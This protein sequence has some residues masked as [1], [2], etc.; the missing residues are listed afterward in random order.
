MD[1]YSPTGPNSQPEINFICQTVLRVELE[2]HSKNG[3]SSN[4]EPEAHDKYRKKSSYGRTIDGTVFKIPE[5]HNM[6]SSLF[7]P[8]LP[9][10]SSDLINL[11]TLTVQMIPLILFPRKKLSKIYLIWFL[12][13]RLLYNVGL[14]WI[15]KNQS[16]NKLLIK[17]VKNLNLLDYKF[18]PRLSCW[19][20]QQL[21]SKML[22]PDLNYD[23]KQFPIEFNV[24]LLF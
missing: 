13:W 22:T 5:T 12:V 16:E 18:N 15:L 8:R 6:I 1:N 17:I 21:K 11:L 24:W 4:T 20:E 7:D 23:L 10:S 3:V 9:K 2:N 19:I 14:G